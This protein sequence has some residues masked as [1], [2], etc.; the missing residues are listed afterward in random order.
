M[1]ASDFDFAGRPVVAVTGLGLVSSLGRGIDDNWRRLLAG[2]S[3]IHAITRFATDTL[4]TT[5]AGTVDFIADDAAASPTRSYAFAESAASEAVAVVPR[6]RML[7][8]PG[9]PDCA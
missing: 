9:P 5:I 8:R 3:G 1:A 7:A 2:E 6:P 4:R